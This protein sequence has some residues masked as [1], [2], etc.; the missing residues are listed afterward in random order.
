MVN[1]RRGKRGMFIALYLVM[2][3]LLMCGLV[4]GFYISHQKQLK[5]SLVSPLKVLEASDDLEIFEMRE[6][7]LALDVVRDVG[8]DKDAF[9]AAFISGLTD[10]M[11]DFIFYNLTYN[12]N[13]A[14]RDDFTEDSFFNNVLYSVS[15]DSGNLIL[16]RNKVGKRIFLK[17][18]KESDVDFSVD[19]VFEFSAE[20]LIKEDN[21]KFILEKV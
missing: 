10:G 6:R 1:D 17:A 4:L 9:K 13:S 18:V 8:L 11:K 20:Y 21:G 3:T 15:E 14:K 12:G 19:F 16:E 7:E 5:G 2:L